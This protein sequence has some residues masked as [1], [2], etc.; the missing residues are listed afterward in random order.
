MTIECEFREKIPSADCRQAGQGG[1]V[2]RRWYY[3]F[4]ARSRCGRACQPASQ[5]GGQCIPCA[6]A[7]NA[8]TYA[9]ALRPG[10]LA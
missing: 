1:R 5:L 10:V 2:G 6:Q 9:P 3:S 8:Y 4:D 7:Q